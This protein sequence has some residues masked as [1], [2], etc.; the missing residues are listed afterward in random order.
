MPGADADIVIF[1]PERE[2]TL[3]RSVLH[4]NCDYTPYDGIALTGYPAMTWLRGQL[5]V[6]D[7]EYVGAARLWPLRDAAR[8]EP[9]M[10]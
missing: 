2:V 9:T 7:G 4:E 6:R 5:L 10:R 1:D 3:S 8:P